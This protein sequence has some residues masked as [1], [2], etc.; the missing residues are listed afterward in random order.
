MDD[1]EKARIVVEAAQEIAKAVPV[2]QDALQPAVREV[3]KALQTVAKTIHIALAPISALVWGYEH[4]RDFILSRVAEKMKQVPSE[5]IVTPSPLVAGP[6]LEALRFAGHDSTLREMYASL[7]ATSLDSETTHLAHPSFVEIIKN[8]SPD[9]AKLIRYMAV[10]QNVPLLDVRNGIKGKTGF[11]LFF[12]NFSMLSYQSIV[13]FNDLLPNYID[14]VARLGIIEIPE[15]TYLVDSENYIPL[16]SSDKIQQMKHDIE[17]DGGEIRFDR[18]VMRLTQ[19]GRQFIK[20]C[21]E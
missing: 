6:T 14:N 12:S 15:G 17:R 8:L 19:L 13:D 10:H 21:V 7:L 1:L 9:E 5:R 16:E 18:K 20:A 11:K 4:I 3:G 2:Y